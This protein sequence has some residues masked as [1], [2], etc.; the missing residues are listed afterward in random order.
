MRN[1][2]IYYMLSYK[3]QQ[4][5]HIIMDH[6]LRLYYLYLYMIQLLCMVFFIQVMLEHLFI[7]V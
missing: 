7:V 1:I 6:I 2:H 3:F 5:N 4:Y